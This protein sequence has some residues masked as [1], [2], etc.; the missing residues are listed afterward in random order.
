MKKLLATLFLLLALAVT[1]PAY[2]QAI[3]PGE[4]AGASMVGT[5]D[6]TIEGSPR[7]PVMKNMTN[8]VIVATLL[9]IEFSDGSQWNITRIHPGGVAPGDTITV[10]VSPHFHKGRPEDELPI[11][12]AT[13]H[14]VMFKDGEIRGDDPT[15]KFRERAEAGVAKNAYAAH[16]RKVA[17]FKI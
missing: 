1:V 16:D 11:V 13:L 7:D 10:G 15:G 9:T 2:A 4:P 6:A 12:A 3:P 17:G 8:K 14:A 5:P